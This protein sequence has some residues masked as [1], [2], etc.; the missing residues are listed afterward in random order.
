MNI[1]PETIVEEQHKAWLQHPTTVQMLKNLD[2][3]KKTFMNMSSRL[4]G[5]LNTPDTQFRLNAYG[6]STIDAIK[7]WIIN[8]DKFVKTS[9]QE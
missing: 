5:D 6:V 3:H 2:K 8:T 4:A 9:Q 7:F 1:T